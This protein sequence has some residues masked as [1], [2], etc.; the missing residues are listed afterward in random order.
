MDDGAV[1]IAFVAVIVAVIVVGVPFVLV[2]EKA[3]LTVGNAVV[4]VAA[5]V[6]I[7]SPETNKLPP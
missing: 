5:G 2:L 7:T 4:G 6:G 3:L 1:I